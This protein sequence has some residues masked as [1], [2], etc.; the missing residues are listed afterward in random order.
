MKWNWKWILILFCPIGIRMYLFTKLV[1]FSFVVIFGPWF[2]FLLPMVPSSFFL[3]DWIFHC[4]CQYTYL[5]VL[6]TCNLSPQWIS[7]AWRRTQN[8]LTYLW[9]LKDAN[10]QENLLTQNMVGFL[11]FELVTNEWFNELNYTLI[12]VQLFELAPNP[13]YLISMITTTF[14]TWFAIKLL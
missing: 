6:L 2:W 3:L 4:H 13:C 14:Y 11:I 10:N 9:N 5:D 1:G 12:N 7:M 8:S